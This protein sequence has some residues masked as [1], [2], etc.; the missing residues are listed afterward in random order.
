MTFLLL[1][2]TLV[3]FVWFFWA[4]WLWYI[5]FIPV[6]FLLFFLSYYTSW[7]AGKIKIWQWRQQYLI[8]LAW[9]VILVWLGGSLHFFGI[10][11]IGI[12]QILIIFNLVFWVWS[13]FAEYDDGKSVFQ[14]W[15][16]L[17][18]IWLVIS[19]YSLWWWIWFWNVFGGVWT[20]NMAIIWF[21]IFIM[22]LRW[23]VS[24]YM[25]Y[26]FGITIIWSIILVIVH[27]IKD[28]YI[29]L[30]LS[31]LLLS[32]IYYIIYKIIKDRPPS[33]QQQKTISVRRILA[34][35]RITQY[36]RPFKQ[37]FHRQVYDMIVNMPILAKYALE[38]LN[39]SLIMIMI[40][41]Y[42]KNIWK[43]IPV[44]HERLYRVIIASFV[45]NVVLLK[46]INYSSIIQRLI[47]FAVINFAIYVSLFS[48]CKGNISQIARSALLWNIFSGILIFYVPKIG[49]WKYFKKIDYI[50]WLI[51]TLIA[52]IINIA[53]FNRTDLP[54]Q[55]LFSIIFLYVGI[56]SITLFYATKHI[57]KMEE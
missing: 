11:N 9:I 54:G 30:F 13:Y 17:S 20:M 47:V 57:S 25:R 39:I 1:L 48:L 40:I 15:Y 12:A 26:E 36:Q 45:W 3:G 27:Q 32:G 38:W 14:L 46:R 10:P 18:I 41:I 44:M 34:G 50:F 42:I 23:G 37:E 2:T 56:Q 51:T 19:A 28:F 24:K 43:I 35:E 22:W 21:M 29:A 31:S 7:V 4:I 5:W 49:I 33:D 6:I 53:L 8:F 55:L 52:M 16:Y